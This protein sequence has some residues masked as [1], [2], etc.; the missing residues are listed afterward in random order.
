MQDESQRPTIMEKIVRTQ[1]HQRHPQ[2]VEQRQTREDVRSIQRVACQAIYDEA[3]H[4]CE[5]RQADRDRVVC[6][7]YEQ[8][9]PDV[10]HL[11]PSEF[12]D[13]AEV[14]HLPAKVLDDLHA[15]K[16]LLQELA[17]LV[18]PTHTLHTQDHE[19]PHRDGL[20]RRAEHEERKTRE[21]AGAEVDEKDDEAN[22]HLD[23]RGQAHLHEATA[24]VDARDIRRDVV[25]ELAV[26]QDRPRARGQLQRSRVD[27][28]DESPT[29]E[30]ACA[31]RTIEEVVCTER[32]DNL[33]EQKPD[34]KPNP[35]ASWGDIVILA[36]LVSAN[37]M[38]VM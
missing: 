4:A 2:Q 29:K 14:R 15:A 38:S 34:S 22:D 25:D 18:R 21:G 7:S 19:A 30:H 1:E 10:A 12:L 24:E 37:A 8:Q 28:S 16:E 20:E 11:L 33:H 3:Q 26:S 13:L 32:R 31:R 35:A 9:V 5:R 36:S 17:P 23:W 27:R 6:A